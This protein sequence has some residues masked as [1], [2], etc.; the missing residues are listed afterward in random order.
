MAIRVEDLKEFVL[1]LKKDKITKKELEKRIKMKWG[2]SDYIYKSRLDALSLFGFIKP[3][4]NNPLVLVINPK[5][6]D[7]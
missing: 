5:G 3:D 4:R 6:D 7:V 1:E 2:I